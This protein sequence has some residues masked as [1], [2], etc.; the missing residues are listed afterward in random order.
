LATTPQRRWQAACPNCGAPV[1]FRSAASATAVC[2]FCRSTL[3]RDAGALRRIGQSAELIEDYS[4]L[5]LGS[6]GRHAGEAFSVVGRLQIGY[7]G[8]SWNEWHVLFEASGRSAWLAE[9]N[10]RFVLSFE[11]PLAEAPPA[12]DALQLGAP[13]TLA[14]QRWQ[15]A[16]L[17]RARV[18]AAQGELPRPPAG[19]FVVAELRNAQDEVGSLEYLDPAKPG[20]PLWSI[21]RQVAL[22]DLALT[23]LREDSGRTLSGRSLPCP[24]CG[25]PLEPRLASTQSITCG[26]CHAV[27]DLSQQEDGAG[28][29]YYAQHAGPDPRIALGSPGAL[30]FDAGA[31]PVD[32]Q[33]VGYQ[34]RRELGDDEPSAWREY[35]LF[36]RTEG[37]AFL[38]DADAGWSLVRP[39]TGAP[40]ETGDT[41]VWHAKRFALKWDYAAETTRVLGEFYWRLQ[42]GERAE[43]R[44]Y[45]LRGVG[46]SELL[47][48]EQMAGEV[49]WSLGRTLDAAEVARAFGPALGAG[50][51]AHPDVQPGAGLLRTIVIVVVVLLVLML[52]L[53]ACTH[54]DCQGWRDSFGPNSAEY[55]QCKARGG[56]RIAPTGTG[57]GGAWGGWGSGGG[58]HK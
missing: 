56:P 23:G 3:V 41:A 46:R 24:S 20:A 52:L 49:V 33:V 16:A 28:L 1:E 50:P 2:G 31:K 10:G 5:Q 11:V 57:A 13:L 32:W 29:A 4:P 9:D 35:L 48:R 36:N 14:G 54:D 51:L 37:F 6:T 43:I 18:A 21:G 26:Q 17:T 15:V 53:R 27:V 25:A 7:E 30:A 47:S 42:K 34:E 58:G 19:A 22:A 8:G 44:D 45:E 12:P 40:V 39:L 38:V 55:L